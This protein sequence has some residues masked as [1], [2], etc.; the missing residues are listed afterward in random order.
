MPGAAV[1]TGEQR[2]LSVERDRAD[3]AFD[4]VVVELDAAVIMKRVSPSQRDT[5]HG[6]GVQQRLS[7][8]V[9]GLQGRCYQNVVAASEALINIERRQCAPARPAIIINGLLNEL[10]RVI[11]ASVFGDNNTSSDL[12]FKGPFNKETPPEGGALFSDA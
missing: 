12:E 1:R 6:V 4:G 10:R 5:N 2:I 8:R 11:T 9:R 7:W 3:G